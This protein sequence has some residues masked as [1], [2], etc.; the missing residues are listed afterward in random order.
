MFSAY[1]AAKSFAFARARSAMEKH[2]HGRYLIDNTFYIR[3]QRNTALIAINYKSNFSLSFLGKKISDAAEI[4][5]KPLKKLK[6]LQTHEKKS[7][8]PSSD[9]YLFK[10][11]PKRHLT[12]LFLKPDLNAVENHVDYRLMK[13]NPSLLPYAREIQ[14]DLLLLLWYR[15]MMRMSAMMS[16]GSNRN[17]IKRGFYSFLFFLRDTL[18]DNSPQYPPHVK[19]I[20]SDVVGA[21]RRLGMVNTRQNGFK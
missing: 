8:P 14:N 4:E 16:N 9:Q 15:K 13:H 18:S 10:I 11:R 17:E 3:N 20:K 19:Q 6:T 2:V 12:S 7:H 5:L 1:E 21:L